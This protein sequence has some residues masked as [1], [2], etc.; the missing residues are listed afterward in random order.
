MSVFRLS[1]LRCCRSWTT[2]TPHSLASLW[3][4]LISWAALLTCPLRLCVRRV[5]SQMSNDHLILLVQM[6]LRLLYQVSSDRQADRQT[7]RQ[8]DINY[9][10]ASWVV[11]WA[12][13]CYYNILRTSRPNYCDDPD[14]RTLTGATPMETGIS[15][16]Q[17]H[18]TDKRRSPC[19][20]N[21]RTSVVFICIQRDSAKN[22]VQC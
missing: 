17:S 19:F 21:T 2:S 9:Y 22:F 10:A 8:T 18:I 15:P 13:I 3:S 7:D 6:T 14:L 20:V 4:Y 12:G 11:K 5:L 16:A 1:L